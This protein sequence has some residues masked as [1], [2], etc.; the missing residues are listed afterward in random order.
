MPLLPKTPMDNPFLRPKQ[1]IF[2]PMEGV[3]D[4]P[5]RIAM[6]K[7]FP[8][9]DRYSTDFLRVPGVG[10]FKENHFIKHFGSECFNSPTHRKKTSFQ[11]LTTFKADTETFVKTADALGFEHLDLNLGCPSKTV[12]SHGGGAFLLTDPLSLSQLLKNIRK[13]FNGFF[14]VK[15][16]I[17]HED[18]KNFLELLKII[19]E[20]GAQALTLHGRTAKQLYRGRAD[21]SYIK[22]AVDFLKIPV[23][24]NGDVW[25]VKDIYDIFEQ[26]NC[27]SVMIGRGAMKSPWLATSYKNSHTNESLKEKLDY[28][29]LYL[30]TLEKEYRNH[31]GVDRTILKRFKALSRYLFDDFKSSTHLK[32]KLLLSESLEEYYRVL[33]TFYKLELTE[34]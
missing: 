18:D 29:S 32:S 5:Y 22:T 6:E 12:N 8:E 4:A 20:E 26:T 21:W 7:A 3:T 10:N 2:A 30:F 33:E 14:S 28:I 34:E 1:I 13:N 31:K 9:W 11:L 23:I 19:Q 24:G 15:M 17:G 16:R 25:N 27:H